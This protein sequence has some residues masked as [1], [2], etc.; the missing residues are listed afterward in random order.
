MSK[1]PKRSSPEAT[2]LSAD[3]AKRLRWHQENQGL[4]I[5]KL[6][7]LAG[8]SSGSLWRVLLDPSRGE[9]LTLFILVR[10]CRAM[11]LDIGE[12]ITGAH[13]SDRIGAFLKPGVVPWVP[14][15]IPRPP[16]GKRP[17]GLRMLPEGEHFLGSPVRRR[18]AAAPSSPKAAAGESRRTRP[19]S[20]QQ[21]EL[22]LPT[23]AGAAPKR[24]KR[25][26]AA[27]KGTRKRR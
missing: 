18:R 7:R 22:Q 20:P 15:A 19:G 12:I 1:L 5:A 10:A 14:K 16:R 27:P 2:A 21:L 3:I 24:S 6:E 26:G 11:N 4:S 13:A 9:S 17:Q 25:R 23:P 8:I